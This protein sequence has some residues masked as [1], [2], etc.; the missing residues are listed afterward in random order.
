[1]CWLAGGQVA[2]DRGGLVRCGLHGGARSLCVVAR[3]RGRSGRRWGRLELIV[4]AL[5]VQAAVGPSRGWARSVLRLARGVRVP[6]TPTSR[7]DVP[8]GAGR[9]GAVPA[10]WSR[11][12]RRRVAASV[13]WTRASPVHHPPA[14][15]RATPERSP[16]GGR[17]QPPR[18]PAHPTRTT[19]A[20][21]P[22][23][24]TRTSA[25]TR[26]TRGTHAPAPRATAQ[27]PGGPDT[28]TQGA[29]PG[30]SPSGTTPIRADRGTRADASGTY[31][32]PHGQRSLHSSATGR[33][34]RCA[35]S[36]SR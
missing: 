16:P 7:D 9:P 17:P 28:P 15:R 35:R 31:G 25:S 19:P 36:G 6:N 4:L 10:S 14:S 12:R 13:R 34:L 33:D 32:P 30:A 11:Q 5:G 18:H 29:G 24:M 3:G 1:M 27:I 2:G 23:Q 22:P 26:P 20:T 8:R 21:A